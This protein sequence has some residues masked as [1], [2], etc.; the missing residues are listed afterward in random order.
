[1]NVLRTAL[2]LAFAG[3]LAACDNSPP[4][5]APAETSETPVVR[6]EPAP[7]A[8]LPTATAPAPEA[9][10]EVAAVPPAPAPS[11]QRPLSRTE[12]AAMEPLFGTWAVDLGSCDRG[13]IAISRTRFEG[14][15]N[16][17][18]ITSIVDQ[19]GWNFVATLSCQSQGQAVRERIGMIPL[20]APTGEAIGL[21]YLDRDNQEVT[22]YRCD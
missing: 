10:P 16:G 22:V 8:P 20:Y 19:G 13:A 4:P 3:L 1:M 17:C 7:A 2:V 14:A 11:S 12:M 18:D 9:E 15:E 21:T 6:T 5:A